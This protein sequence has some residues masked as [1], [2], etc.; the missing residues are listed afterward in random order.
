M[1]PD[2]ETIAEFPAQIAVADDDAF[3]IGLGLTV[4]LSVFVPIQPKPLLPVT[5]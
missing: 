2:A 1:A 3:T 5:V 4:I